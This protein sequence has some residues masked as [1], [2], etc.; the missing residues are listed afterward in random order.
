MIVVPDPAP[1]M[2]VLV[3]VMSRS[4][5]ALLPENPSPAPPGILNWYVPAGRMMVVPGLAFAKVTAPRKLQSLAAAVH[6]DAPA[7]SSVRST[8]IEANIIGIAAFIGVL[9]ALA[10]GALSRR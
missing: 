10:P 2:V 9:W 1:L 5:I 3:A 8:V 4:P 7:A 6:A